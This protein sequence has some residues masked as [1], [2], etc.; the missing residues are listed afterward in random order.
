MISLVLPH[1]R[2]F[3]FSQLTAACCTPRTHVCK[4]KFIEYKAYVETTIEIDTLE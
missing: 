3:Y 4:K 1:R 2:L